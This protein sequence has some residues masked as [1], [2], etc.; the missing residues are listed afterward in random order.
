MTTHAWK[1]DLQ[2]MIEGPG[3]IPMQRIRE[4]TDEEF[5]HC[6]E[7][8]FYTLGP[9]F[10]RSRALKM[11]RYRTAIP[12]VHQVLCEPRGVISPSLR[13]TTKLEFWRAD[14]CGVDAGVLIATFRRAAPGRCSAFADV[15]RIVAADE[16]G[17]VR[18]RSD[19]PVPQVMRRLQ[20][21]QSNR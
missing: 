7:A 9:M 2:V 13:N 11:Y 4:N 19:H 20:L 15:R 17:R 5:R 6:F 21:P 16:G 10:T 12:R 3:H 1:H 8:P 18:T 14:F